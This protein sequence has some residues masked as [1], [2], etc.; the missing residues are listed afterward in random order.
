VTGRWEARLPTT[1]RVVH[2]S[3]P[4]SSV[5]R[6]SRFVAGFDSHEESAQTHAAGGSFVASSRVSH[7]AVD[8]VIPVEARLFM[9]HPSGT[10][11]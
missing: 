3:V 6:P 4:D 2:D 1:A 5:K 9:S 11:A 10:V 8:A 7:I